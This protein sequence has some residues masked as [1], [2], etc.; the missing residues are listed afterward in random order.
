M[1][2]PGI[3]SGG[4]FND[5]FGTTGTNLPI[6]TTSGFSGSFDVGAVAGGFA[7]PSDVSGFDQAGF[8]T[9]G[10][11]FDSSTTPGQ[12]GPGLTPLPQIQPNFSTFDSSKF[13]LGGFDI[14]APGGK[15]S[16]DPKT[17]FNFESG[18]GGLRSERALAFKNAADEEDRLAE[19]FNFAPLTKARLA[20][21]DRAEIQIEREKSEAVGTLRDQ[22]ASRRILGA[23]F[24][25]SQVKRE[26]ARFD[27]RKDDLRARRALVAGESKLE[28]FKLR[29]EH[30][31]NANKLRIQQFQTEITEIFGETELAIQAGT[32]F[33][34]LLESNLRARLA[35]EFADLEQTRNLAQREKESLRGDVRAGEEREDR[36]SAGF[37]T[38]IGSLLTAPG[39]SLIGGLFG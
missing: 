7:D 10:D 33:A 22:L 15:F 14:N 5:P 8:Q 21:F 20:Q 3:F 12:F 1:A 18:L 2:L 39:S 23:S 11:S 32:Q 17:G 6:G 29:T 24:A 36:S 37:G 34:S 38:L 13:G 30:L 16:F 35:I 25:T 28:E 27:L 31:Q 9:G 19:S 26:A 4:Q